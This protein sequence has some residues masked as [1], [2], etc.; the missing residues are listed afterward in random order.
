LTFGVYILAPRVYWNFNLS[1][2]TNPN[3]KGER[4][5]LWKSYYVDDAVY[6]FLIGKDIEDA[7]RLVKTLFRRL[8]LTVYCGDKKQNKSSKTEAMFILEPNHQTTPG[9]TADIM[10]NE[11]EYLGF[12]EECKSLGTK[13]TPSF[14]DS[15]DINQRIKKATAAFKPCQQY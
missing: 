3:T 9:D 7:S 8:G 12:W 14:D 4:F 11:V 5:S 2:A 6:I 1:K 15:V 10:L 13:C